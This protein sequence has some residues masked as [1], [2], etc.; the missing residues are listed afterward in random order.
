MSVALAIAYDYDIP[1]PENAAEHQDTPAFF[2]S[3]PRDDRKE[4]SGSSR[5]ANVGPRRVP[6]FYIEP[7]VFQVKA[8]D[9]VYQSIFQSW[10]TSSLKVGNS[11]F[12]VPKNG[13]QVSGTIFEAMFSLPSDDAAGSIEGSSDENPIHLHGIEEKKFTAFL[14]VLYPS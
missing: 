9:I 1:K 5:N 11:L 4:A 14:T 13:F 6:Q 12:K 7:V 3:G 2:N 8:H 10:H